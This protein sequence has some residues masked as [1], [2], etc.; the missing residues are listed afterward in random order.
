MVSGDGL[1]LEFGTYK[2]GSIGRI[3]SYSQHVV[4][5]FDSFEG[6][7]E[8]WAGRIEP[9]NWGFPK[10]SFSLGG[11]VPQACPG[12]VL[13]KGWFKDTIPEFLKQHGGGMVMF[14]H[15]D[16]D[17][18]SSARDV[19]DNLGPRLAPGCIMV[20]DEMVGYANFE[21]HEWKA[22]WEF[23]DANGV[24]FEWIGGNA[25]RQVLP[26]AAGVRPFSRPGEA[27][28]P[29]YE[30]VALRITRNPLI[31]AKRPYFIGVAGESGVGKTTIANAMAFFLGQENVLVISTDDLH[32]WERASPMWNI[33]THSNPDANNLDLG[34][35]HVASLARGDPIYR[36]SYN[37]DKGYFDPPR[38]VFPRP[39]V[40][41][42]GLH[43][44]FSPVANNLMGLRVFVD[45]ADALRVS[46]KVL[47][48]TKCRGY[49]KGE[50][51]EAISRRRTDDAL[52]RSVQL[53]RANAVIKLGSAP[54]GGLEISVRQVG[55]PR[56]EAM[57]DFV[58]RS[59]EGK[60]W[61]ILA[62]GQGG[63][64]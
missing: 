33:L 24:E 37:H 51:E 53:G 49:S 35:Q 54:G 18:Y 50:V 61:D 14:V 39:Y 4:Y 29:S 44:F 27:A 55:G 3:A 34:D 64:P 60:P 5:G 17:I 25:S 21:N 42:E 20:F 59:L 36:S 46:W 43:A 7:P 41:N 62:Y 2:G 10:G 26:P 57:L 12:V 6:L 13:V 11:I 22:W 8:D 9:G 1:W 58:A 28:S 56:Q 52:I 63:R 45:T 31:M 23:V 47:R 15:V 38:K 16:S 40:I 30:N 48:D 32:K 19:L